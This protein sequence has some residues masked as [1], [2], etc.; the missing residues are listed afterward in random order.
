MQPRATDADAAS[1]LV[2]RE[3]VDR[4]TA[5]AGRPDAPSVR[6]ARSGSSHRSARP[7]PSANDQANLPALPDELLAALS[8]EPPGEAAARD[9]S[10]PLGGLA[11]GRTS[12]VVE[13]D[14]PTFLNPLPPTL[15]DVA[16]QSPFG[17]AYPLA[18]SSSSV[19]VAS[20]TTPRAAPQSPGM[21]PAAPVD[22][23]SANR[24]NAGTAYSPLDAPAHPTEPSPLRRSPAASPPTPRTLP[25]TS[26]SK[27]N[28]F[29]AF[30]FSRARAPQPP[31]PISATAAGEY[32]VPPNLSPPPPAGEGESRPPSQWSRVANAPPALATT[33][34]APVSSSAA[35]PRPAPLPHVLERTRTDSSATTAPSLDDDEEDDDGDAQDLLVRP[36]A[37]RTRWSARPGAAAEQ[38][39]RDLRGARRESAR[40]GGAA[41]GKEENGLAY[42][43]G[44][45]DE[46]DEGEEDSVEREEEGARAVERRASSLSLRHQL[47]AFPR[48]EDPLPLRLPVH[49]EGDDEVTASD[50][51][52]RLSRLDLNGLGGEGRAPAPASPHDQLQ[53][54]QQKQQQRS[55]VSSADFIV[56][57]VGPRNVGKSTVIRRGLK[58]PPAA[59]TVLQEDDEGNRVTTSTTS[60]SISGARRT[61]EVLEIDMGLLRYSDEGVVWPDGLPQ[62]EGAMLWCAAFCLDV[63]ESEGDSLTDQV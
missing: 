55:P 19:A 52:R 25:T 5:P 47:A 15:P 62:C 50:A 7:E 41:G 61:I 53:E 35:R 28:V 22:G 59:P 16:P 6:S 33:S 34:T 17:L 45:E 39:T 1:R 60:F 42:D 32:A 14:R 3:T 31:L 56:A 24:T 51:A 11:N 2:P 44:E 29:K 9:P 43:D 8:R 58:R 37:D 49:V 18:S 13:T 40:S 36:E 23:F 27:R 30:S 57:V 20:P 38:F 48:V 21:T 54:Q 46:D 63:E 26:P 4:G 12:L 10:A